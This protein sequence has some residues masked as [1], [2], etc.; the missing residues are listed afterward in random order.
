MFDKDLAILI[1][2]ILLLL[3]IKDILLVIL[4][5][6][7]ICILLHYAIDDTTWNNIF[8]VSTK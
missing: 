4:I 8:G 2:I 3:F 5:T 6:C 1:A 7:V